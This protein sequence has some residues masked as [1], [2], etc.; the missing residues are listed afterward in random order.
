MN[1]TTD[2]AG[3]YIN[4]DRSEARR[5]ETEAELARHNLSSRYQRFAAAEGNVLNAPNPENLNAGALGCFT[6]HYLLL[7]ENLGSE[8]HLHI[9]E[10]DVFFA[11]CAE[12][13]IHW[14]IASGF[15]DAYD[16]VYTDL[17]I[18]LRNEIYK[19]YK[20]DY[21]KAVTRSASGGIQ[22]VAF[23]VLNMRERTFASTSSFL[24]NRASIGKLH[25]ML[26]AELMKGAEGPVDLVLRYKNFQGALKVGCIFPFVTSVGIKNTLASTVDTNPDR[27]MELAMTLARMMFFI[28]SDWAQCQ[29]H[30]D[31]CAPKPS[32]DDPL[33]AMLGQ[34]LTY[35]LSDTYSFS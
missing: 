31:I 12:R 19:L 24:V 6:S 27:D 32:P 13:V 33:A 10:D 34:L 2:Y 16:I 1:D 23:E 3:F 8:K 15:L 5:A 20:A 18:P 4:L 14:V 17:S 11:S 9:I 35:S 22:S 30:L 29:T 7:K 25:D 28:E 26:G 21:D